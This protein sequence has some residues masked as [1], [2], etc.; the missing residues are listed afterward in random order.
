MRT[1]T[2]THPKRETP[3]HPQ[4]VEATAWRKDKSLSPALVHITASSDAAR[5]AA[6]TLDLWKTAI[7]VSEPR[8][9]FLVGF[10][11]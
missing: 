4:L 9:M 3:R 10:Q 2:H 1:R 8:L 11:L 5:R 7:H 6:A